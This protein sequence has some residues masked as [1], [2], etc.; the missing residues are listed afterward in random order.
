VP[1][2]AWKTA[3]DADG[4]PREGVQI[5]ELTR[6]LAGTFLGWLPDLRVIARRER[7]HPGAQLRALYVVVLVIAVARSRVELDVTI[8]N[9]DDR[10]SSRVK[11]EQGDRLCSQSRRCLLRR[12]AR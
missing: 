1:R 4:V 10:L 6:E 11:P 9:Q 3:L 2:Q 5:A 12:R 8:Y 7:P